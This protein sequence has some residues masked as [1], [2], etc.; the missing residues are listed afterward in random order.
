[1]TMIN[2]KGYD[3]IVRNH[4]MYNKNWSSKLHP[5]LGE[6]LILSWVNWM[7]ENN[8]EYE[9]P[10]KTDLFLAE[11]ETRA[12]TE[13]IEKLPKDR[14]GIILIEAESESGQSFW[15]G[16]WTDVIAKKLHTMGYIVLI[17]SVKEAPLAKNLQTTTGNRVIWMGDYTLR[18]MAAFYDH[19]DAFISVSSGLSNAC[20]TQQRKIIPTWIE[21]VNS[22][23][24][25]SNVIRSTG[26]TFWHDNNLQNFC[27]FIANTL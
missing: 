1:M 15:N 25:S 13:F 20:N 3:L 6:N 11:E 2:P 18:T 17:N 16:Q 27:D 5:E 8:I 4:P 19:S 26:K 7:E 10:L 12:P 24:C 9:Y 21:V 22:L 23:T 14:K